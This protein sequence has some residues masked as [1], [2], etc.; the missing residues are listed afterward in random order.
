MRDATTRLFRNRR[1]GAV[2]R[3]P[4][5]LRAVS[6]ALAIAGIIVLSGCGDTLPDGPEGLPYTLEK[7]SA[8]F[9]GALDCELA[10]LDG[11]GVDEMVTVHAAPAAA[12]YYVGVRRI[13]PDNILMLRQWIQPWL[14]RLSGF[15]DVDGDGLPEILITY[16]EGTEW[17]CILAL[18]VEIT[19]DSASVDTL[20]GVRPLR[21]PLPPTLIGGTRWDGRLMTH[22]LA[23]LDGDG[24][25]ETVTFSSS[26]GMAK[27]PRGIGRGNLLTGEL[28]W[29][30]PFAG[31]PDELVC[32]AD[33][34]GDGE[35]EYAA[36]FNSP[37]NNVTVRD[38]V[39]SVAYVGAVDGDGSVIWRHRL[40]G[41]SAS[42]W[43]C[44]GD[45]TGDGRLEV[46][47]WRWHGTAAR[48]ETTRVIVRDGATGDL[49]GSW[50]ARGNIYAVALGGERAPGVI[51]AGCEDGFVR[52]LRW[53]SRGLILEREIDCGAVPQGM[54]VIELPPI[55]DPV[56]VCMTADGTVAVLDRE[57][58]PLAILPTDDAHDCHASIRPAV[59]SS[60]WKGVSIGIATGGLQG[61]VLL[62]ARPSPLSA[63]VFVAVGGSVLLLV[64]LGVP[65]SR[66]RLLAALRRLVIPTAD[67]EKALD[68]LLASLARAGH[69]KLAATSTMRR[70]ADQLTLLV[71]VEP[72][73]P[74]R[75]RERYREAL[76]N[77]R[78]VGLP[79]VRSIHAQ[80]VRVGLDPAAASELLRA[81]RRTG[82]RLRRMP[83]E[84]PN[85]KEASRLAGELEELTTSLDLA[86]DAVL[87]RCRVELSTDLMREIRR[88][89]GARRSD[90]LQTGAELALPAISRA[91]G[92]RVLGTR[93]EISF[94]IE[95]LIANALA[96]VEG[97]EE[98]RVAV[99]VEPDG[100]D[101]RVRVRDTG[102]GIP[103]EMRERVFADGV[104]TRAGGGH[105]LP[106]SRRILARR[107][108]SIEIVESTP[109]RGSTFEVRLKIVDGGTP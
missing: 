90:Y 28:L 77:V 52:K 38:M 96:A 82:D 103:S 88:A 10:D 20:A 85:G 40:A 108:G 73:I 43:P 31:V 55:E 12:Y 1:R 33:L 5:A 93:T 2:A 56:L 68:E 63:W 57:L 74:E 29:F 100:G 66:R 78:Q 14:H 25:R 67:R 81:L 53:T 80:A 35:N 105:G 99:A 58:E 16:Q 64:V 37:D 3:R 89:A 94:I 69:G 91:E 72:P 50:P 19:G 22:D 32:A 104:S 109:G 7:Y 101:A 18:D 62:E 44:C 21:V 70:L 75:F 61:L 102:V 87:A 59:F 48:P 86:L 97:S 9:D 4:P 13:R 39:D 23:D 107:E 17:G 54:R 24:L 36:A 83:A 45:V 95:N 106:D 65:G 60:T 26:A 47:T 71:G 42:G 6:H 98:K 27:G 49:L 34:D 92:I 76:D 79:G 8:R 46:V 84:L 41:R 30:T 11:D 15:G 51:Y